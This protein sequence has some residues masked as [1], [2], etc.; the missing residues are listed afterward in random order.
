MRLPFFAFA[1]SSFRPSH[2]RL[3]D[4]WSLLTFALSSTTVV[5]IHMYWGDFIGHRRQPRETNLHH[6]KESTKEAQ[7]TRGD[8]KI[9]PQLLSLDLDGAALDPCGWQFGDRH[10]PGWTMWGN[11]KTG[12][13]KWR[14]GVAL[15]WEYLGIPQNRTKTTSKRH[16]QA[17]QTAPWSNQAVLAPPDEASNG[18]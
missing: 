7:E 1:P 18:K 6:C 17:H 13:G 2:P 16:Q 3:P 15:M 11:G 14:S 10:R 5:L 9:T 4:L 8:K 12:T